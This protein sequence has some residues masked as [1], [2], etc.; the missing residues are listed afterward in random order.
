MDTTATK[1]HQRVN[2][3]SDR[4]LPVQSDSSIQ[5]CWFNN[6][7]CCNGIQSRFDAAGGS[8]NSS[9]KFNWNRIIMLPGVFHCFHLVL[10][11][12]TRLMATRFRSCKRE[13]T[14]KKEIVSSY[15]TLTLLSFV[16]FI[17]RVCDILCNREI[18][19]ESIIS[20]GNGSFHLHWTAKLQVYWSC[21][22]S[23]LFEVDEKRKET[24]HSISFRN[25]GTVMLETTI[26]IYFTMVIKLLRI[27]R[28]ADF[29]SF[30]NHV[31]ITI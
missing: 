6:E 14:K 18:M 16:C 21:S 24:V 27:S 13:K 28:I 25:K 4:K 9:I 20:S 3:G 8:L 26:I 15:N 1:C 30:P 31:Y 19:V 2:G 11:V 5:F 23:H 17:H 22:V 10:L 12:A 7:F 29:L